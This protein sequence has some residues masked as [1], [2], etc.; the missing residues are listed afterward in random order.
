M[1]DETDLRE[2]SRQFTLRM[3]ETFKALDNL[4]YTASRFH[5]MLIQENDGVAVARRL[6]IGVDSAGLERLQ[7][8][9]RLDL[10][11]EM[12]VL[13]PKYEQLFDQT[14]REYASAKLSA[15]GFDV[16]AEIRRK[17]SI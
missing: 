3:Y 13:R 16:D 17:E 9:G 2:L 12:W 4:G 1:S 8:M 6:V 7:K 15:M 11:V 10:S 14:T 5:Q